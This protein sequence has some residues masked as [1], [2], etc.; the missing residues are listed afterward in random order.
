MEVGPHSMPDGD[1]HCIA[2]NL[3]KE[4]E[5]AE[6]IE[7]DKG[8]CIADDLSRLEDQQSLDTII[9]E[10]LK[11]RCALIPE[12][13]TPKVGMVFKTEEEA[14]DFYNVYA[15]KVGFSTRKS[16]RNLCPITGV[17]KFRRFC[18]SKEGKR[19]EDKRRINAKHRR[20]ETRCGC[21]AELKI[22]LR[23]DGF[24]H[25]VSFNETHNHI[26]ATPDK[27]HMLRS[28]RKL[29]EAQATQTKMTNKSG[30]TSKA[31]RELMSEN[32]CGHENVEFISSDL[33]NYLHSY[34]SGNMEKGEAGGFLQY[35]QDMQSKDPSFVYAIQLDQAELITNLFWADAQMIIDYGHF[36]DVVLFD[37]TY[38]TNNEHR[39]FA[40]FV[41]VN[42]YKQ[43]IVFGVAMLY[44][45]TPN[46]FEWLFK[47]FI[48]TMGGK[49]P[50][51]ILID[52]DAAMVNAINLVLPE[53]HHQLCVWHIFQNARKHLSDVFEKFKT[54]S[55]DFG[56]CLYDY[57]DVSE[58][59]NAWENMINK[60]NIQDN[61]WLQKLYSKR[62]RWDL[63]FGRETF[64]ADISTTQRNESMSNRLKKYLQ[65]KYDLSEFLQHFERVIAEKRY[66]ELKAEFATTQNI[67]TLIMQVDILNFASQIYTPPIF[68][69]FYNEVWQQLN[70]SIEED[71]VVTGTMTEY[72]VSVSGK[73][74][75]HK[76]AFDSVD[77]SVSCSCKKFEHVGILCGHAL[78]VL[79]YRRIK[80]IPSRYILKRWTIDAKVTAVEAFCGSTIL[81]DR[82]LMATLRYK[83]MY[84][85]FI[86][87]ANKA[88]LAEDT[89]KVVMEI[90]EKLLK[91]VTGCLKHMTF[92]QS[93]VASEGMEVETNDTT[94]LPCKDLDHIN[95]ASSN[96]VISAEGGT[97]NVHSLKRPSRN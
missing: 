94:S 61:D 11:E 67:P 29:F 44:D 77:D 42:S 78:K 38:R 88:A 4:N 6:P 39:P 69:M 66:E 95:D 51:T 60:Y 31:S 45:E 56:S 59:E 30:I 13:L 1:K 43:S 96:N 7:L 65:I 70:C 25:V 53:S 12:E 62:H 15:G 73:N 5:P 91:E 71:H 35:F 14:Y 89:Y 79:D 87:I 40:L 24:F 9:K 80:T 23:E 68:S 37:T 76:V 21:M 86:Q 32:V 97:S 46:T 58:F 36:G 26:I 2:N 47:T 75:Q 10:K 92:D 22:S 64:C 83:E 20:P 41:G 33:K 81:S 74:H 93:F 72:V 90:A 19:T 16:N 17:V 85:L 63:V 49:K 55:K 18:C 28:Q 52:D 48:K 34:R 3:P 8:K 50:K 57:E 84:R 27:V 82:S 54:F